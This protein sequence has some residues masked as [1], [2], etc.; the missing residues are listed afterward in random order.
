MFDPVDAV[1]ATAQVQGFLELAHDAPQGAAHAV[2]LDIAA[3]AYAVLVPH[4][5]TARSV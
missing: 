2:D 3:A 1:A 5:S 4:Q